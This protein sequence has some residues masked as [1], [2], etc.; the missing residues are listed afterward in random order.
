MVKNNIQHTFVVLAGSN[1]YVEIDTHRR[2]PVYFT[3]H[4]SN[5]LNMFAPA[6]GHVI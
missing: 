2:V 5:C 6:P 4:S 1:S 3:D